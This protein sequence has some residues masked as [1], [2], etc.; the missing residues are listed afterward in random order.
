LPEDV[1]KL[2]ES[3]AR[4]DQVIEALKRANLKYKEE[5]GIL[6]VTKGK[7]EIARLTVNSDGTVQL[8][9]EQPAETPPEE[10]SKE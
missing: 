2:V 3:G 10:D 6:I 5:N 1:A 8:A 7:K 4:E 9:K